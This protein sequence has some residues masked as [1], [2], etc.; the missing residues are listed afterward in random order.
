MIEFLKKQ[1]WPKPSYV[2]YALAGFLFLNL[3]WVVAAQLV[4]VFRPY[5]NYD[6]G[7]A[8]LLAPFSVGLSFLA[9]L[10]VYALELFIINSL[11]FHFDGAG[12][13]FRSSQFAGELMLQ[14]FVSLRDLLL[15]ALFLVFAFA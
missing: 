2:A 8:L 14:D 10:V 7:L 15:L 5:L 11:V 12:D 3:F 9:L 13:F 6:Y 1:L 4:F